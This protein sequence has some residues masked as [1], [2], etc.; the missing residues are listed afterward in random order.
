MKLTLSGRAS[1]GFARV[2]STTL[3]LSA[4]AAQ[5]ED[6]AHPLHIDVPTTSVTANPLNSAADQL[7]PPIHVLNGRELFY[8]RESTLGE[9][10]NGLPGVR[11]T[12]FG[13]NASRPVIRG[14]DADRIR[15]LQNGVGT[16]DLSS[17]SPDHAIPL[18]PLVVE[19]IDV[20]RG[21]AALQY[22]GSAVGGV[23]NATDNRIPREAIEGIG[24][25]G[26]VRYGGAASER[27][28]AALLEAGNGR[29]A[30]H[31]DFYQ[32]DT[33]DLEI[34]GYARSSALRARD[35]QPDEPRNRLG[36][37]A[38]NS[39]GGAL[40]ASV[41]GDHGY[42]GIAYSESRT[43]YGTVAEPGVTID[44]RNQRWD[45]AGEL[46]EM[47][48]PF[49]RVKARFGNTDYIHKEIDGGV[50][51]TTFT[52]RGWEGSIEAAHAAVGPL[53]GV[54]GLQSHRSRLRVTGDEALLP[55]V[56]TDMDAVYV[57]EEWPLEL[58]ARPFKLSFGGRIERN[59]VDSAGGG[60][61]DANNPGTPRF[62]DAVT[63]RFTPRSY[64]A[65]GLW[66]LSPSWTLTGNLSH[67]E[68]APTY[69]EL[70]SDGPHAATGQY[71]VGNRDLSVEKSNGLDVGLRWSQGRN[72]AGVSVFRT[73]F[74]NYI[75]LFSTGDR[76]EEDGLIDPAG[77]LPEARFIAVPAVFQGLEF[78]SRFHVYEG[79]GDLDLSLRADYVHATNDRTGDPLPR[80]APLRLGF[81]LDYV[82][83]RLNAR[84]DVSRSFDQN[85]NAAEEL[86]TDGYTMVN[87]LVSYHLPTRLHLD[88][89]L[90]ATNLLDQEAREH[91]SI[92]KD[93]APLGG[94]AIMVGL[95]GEF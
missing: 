35:P 15:L 32:R 65:G 52:N 56:K 40:G 80:I 12:Y 31:A 61:D 68:R 76:R 67:N 62:G 37:S 91:T 18:D 69:F 86:E 89:F 51:G 49:S 63:R 48:G 22:G 41:T 95:R 77:E 13:P 21:P 50:V 81:G 58:A 79:K 20:V 11:S 39:G 75:G 6:E 71:E 42:A 90:K 55:R 57:V 74:S 83:N 9:T 4:P 94:R 88:A 34:P 53:N 44:M 46:R 93:I 2:L 47:N 66:Q 92:I 33:S 24:G 73:R 8:R 23:V 25:R 16:L 14:L 1:L 87:A 70:F 19:Q 82:F 84:L 3:A 59:A 28:Q 60:P 36:N 10:L 85:R 45:L 7:V 27:S 64:S 26:E 17:L 5:A 54:I 72:N 29:V 43:D 38:A 78:T 30:L